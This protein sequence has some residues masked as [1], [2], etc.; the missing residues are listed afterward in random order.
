M[1]DRIEDDICK[2]LF[3]LQAAESRPFDEQEGDDYDAPL[4]DNGGE[5]V[6]VSA[7]QRHATQSVFEDFT[8]NIERKKQKELDAIQFVGPTSANP[9][10]QALNKNKDVGRNDP[11]P[12]GSGKKYKK[13]HGA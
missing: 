8:R 2:Y 5:P 4:D 9:T 3:F 1:R 11:C 12:C 6:G 7:E 13:C 10:K